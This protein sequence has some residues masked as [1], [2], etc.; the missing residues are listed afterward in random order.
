MPNEIFFQFDKQ[1]DL[2]NFLNLKI[3]G[4]GEIKEYI[5]LIQHRNHMAF[6][7]PEKYLQN[8]QSNH[9]LY[10][11]DH[12]GDN[13][14]RDSI[15]INEIN[16]ILDGTNCKLYK[17][18]NPYPKEFWIFENGEYI[19]SKDEIWASIYTI[20]KNN[21]F[22]IF[23]KY[24]TNDGLGNNTL[25][26]PILNGYPLIPQDYYTEL[27]RLNGGLPE[28]EEIPKYSVVKSSCGKTDELGT[29]EEI[30]GTIDFLS[31]KINETGRS[32]LAEKLNT[33]IAYI[34]IIKNEK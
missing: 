6:F 26:I 28:R 31:F 34:D 9:N 29:L 32:I 2:A 15:S 10:F 5:K 21:Q 7:E 24:Y 17:A 30:I 3:E 13:T 25:Y 19:M 8:D 27:V 22:F 1:E 12:N 20:N 33:K 18:I 14:I 11:K 4:C 16:L 23:S